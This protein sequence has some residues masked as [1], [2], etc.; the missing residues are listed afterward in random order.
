LRAAQRKTPLAPRISKR[1][2]VRSPI[3]EVAP[4]FCGCVANLE[5]GRED[6]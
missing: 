2:R 3:F 6:G 5:Q 1:R 4:N